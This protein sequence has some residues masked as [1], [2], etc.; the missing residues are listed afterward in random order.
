MHAGFL[1]GDAVKV[2]AMIVVLSLSMSA[3]AERF[4]VSALPVS[5]WVDTEVETN[6]SFS[7]G[8]AA[9]N[10][11]SVAIELDASPSNSVEVVLGV[12]LDNDGELGLAEGEF[13]IGWDAC[14]WF[15]R[16]RRA[17]NIRRASADAGR[18]RLN[19]TLYLRQDRSI[20]QLE[21][22]VFDGSFL[23]T[24]FNQEWNVVR[25]VVSGPDAANARIDGGVLSHGYFVEIR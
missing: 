13:A 1:G 21:S 3:Y 7:A 5:A 4:S 6:M 15:V 22:N 11:L 25:V 14:E 8:S 20:R 17:N 24:Y 19:W 2:F 9:D 16:D 12:D 23:P 10:R 18:I